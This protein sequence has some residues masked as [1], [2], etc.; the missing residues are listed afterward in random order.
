M[1][2]VLV[3]ILVLITSCGG[4]STPPNGDS[5]SDVKVGA[6][7]V[8]IFGQSKINKPEVVQQLVKIIKNYDLI[9]I[10]EIRDASGSSIYTL[11]TEL[12]KDTDDYSLIVGSRVG[13]S[14]SKE[15]HAFFYKRSLLKV[16][17]TYETP[18]YYDVFEREPFNVLFQHNYSSEKFIATGIHIKPT[19]APSEINA[20]YSHFTEV[21]NHFS[22]SNSIILGDMNAD[23]TYLS[24]AE[25]YSLYFTGDSF[26]KWEFQKNG[27]VN[28]TTVSNTTCTYDQIITAGDLKYKVKKN[29]QHIF[30]FD[31]E[32]SL[33]Q[34]QALEISDHYPVGL[35][36][37]F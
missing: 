7:N 21:S 30:K 1:K 11:L 26:F 16:I 24:N 37:S 17:G 29:T 27:G 13:R 15:Q 8:Q 12:N 31:N 34:P 19:D 32:Y 5:L 20:L 25:F 28:D 33:S 22:S 3:L 4:V 35:T 2:N 10:Q 36:L 23:C 18:D 14:S 6:F 9:L